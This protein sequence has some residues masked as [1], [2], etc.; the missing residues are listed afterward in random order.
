MHA[1]FALLLCV[2]LTGCYVKLYGHESASGGTAT[3]T[4]SSQ[5]TGSAKFSGGR[6]SFASGRPVSPSAPGGHV[7][8]NRNASAA[9][10]VGLIIADVVN[11]FR[12]KPEQLAGP[13]ESISHTCSCYKPVTGDR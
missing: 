7:S 9:L 6:V 5:V 10:V 4:T 12:A 13:R 2:P 3:A 8:L 11:Y 1:V